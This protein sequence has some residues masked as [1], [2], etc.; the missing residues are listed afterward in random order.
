MRI[1][2]DKE[3]L[4]NGMRGYPHSYDENDRIRDMH[5][6][7][8]SDGSSRPCRFGAVGESAVGDDESK[9]HAAYGISFSDDDGGMSG[10]ARDFVSEFYG[11]SIELVEAP[12]V[13]D[14]DY[15]TEPDYGRLEEPGDAY[16]D[17]LYGSMTE[18]TEENEL[19]SYARLR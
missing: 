14:G 5:R 4:T 3:G 8:F 2:L 19:S 9:C 6:A 18:L 16:L 1:Y 15:G 11:N 13:E 7:V 17:K 10:E 12:G